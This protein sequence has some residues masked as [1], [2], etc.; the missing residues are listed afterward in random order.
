MLRALGG[1]SALMILVAMPGILSSL[2]IGVLP[3]ATIF[4]FLLTL[5]G[6]ALIFKGLR[7]SWVDRPLGL[8]QGVLICLT[9]GVVGFGAGE[10]AVKAVMMSNMALISAQHMTVT[11]WSVAM[12]LGAVAGITGVL[13]SFIW[14]VSGSREMFGQGT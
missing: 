11:L 2:S 10:L 14:D 4:Y 3:H 8:R 13:V 5:S 6:C 12:T 1:G 7:P 9:L